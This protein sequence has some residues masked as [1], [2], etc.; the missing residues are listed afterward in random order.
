MIKIRIWR[1]ASPVFIVAILL[2]TVVMVRG[3]GSA[4][5]SSWVMS[6][7]VY[8][9]RLNGGFSISVGSARSGT[10]NQTFNLTSR[11][12]SSIHVGSQSDS[13]EII[14]IISQRNGAENRYDISN[15]EGSLPIVGL[16]AGRIRFSLQ[17]DS[18]RNS[19]TTIRWR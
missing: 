4:N 10:R 3:G 14:L 8:E 11:E 17:Y 7:N 6:R 16:Y 19:N 5:S 1:K 12:L 9:N 15:F 2:F 13:G 18:I